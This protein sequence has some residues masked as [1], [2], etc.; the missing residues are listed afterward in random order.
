MGRRPKRLPISFL[1]AFSPLF[2]RIFFFLPRA[3]W[4]AWWVS[5]FTPQLSKRDKQVF[6][7]GSFQEV[8]G[9]LELLRVAVAF[10]GLLSTKHSQL[11]QKL[12]LLVGEAVEICGY[13]LN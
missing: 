4:L 6:N 13:L 7:P 9:L 3:C 10:P 12:D 8:N 1:P 5:G 11:R 2:E